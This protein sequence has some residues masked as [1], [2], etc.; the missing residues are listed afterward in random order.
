MKKLT[1]FTILF[2]SPAAAHP[3]HLGG[4]AGHDH[5]VA[6]IAIGAAVGVSIWGI[7]KE[8]RRKKG[9]EGSPERGKAKGGEGEQKPQEA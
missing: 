5:W 3:G 1:V 4:L 8:R 2:A 9:G 6:G 7:L